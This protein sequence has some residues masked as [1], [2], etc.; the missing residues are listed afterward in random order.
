MVILR[1]GHGG[2][3]HLQQDRR[4]R[5][6]GMAENGR[7]LVYAFSPDFIQHLPGFA[8]CDPD[9]TRNSSGFHLISLPLKEYSLNRLS[10]FYFK[11]VERSVWLLCLRKSRVGASSP[12]L[13]PTI[14][15]VIYIGT[16]FRPSC[17]AMV[18]P[19][20]SG[21]IV[22]LRAQVLM[23]LFSP[24]LF[25]SSIFLRRLASIYGP[26]FNE[27]DIPL[28]PFHLYLRRLIIRRSEGFFLLVRRP[29]AGFPQGVTGARPIG[30]LP[31]PPPCG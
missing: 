7:C 4:R 6:W 3:Q 31:S 27:R 2:I 8:R 19:T 5:P 26:F 29:S 21:K 22:E 10:F 24:R 15:S 23:T 12:Y 18:W 1:I 14:S 28:L 11:A 17:T 25:I 13:C 9:I 16:C 20:I 30:D